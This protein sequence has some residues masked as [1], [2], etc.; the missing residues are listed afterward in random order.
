MN[1]RTVL[2]DS[3]EVSNLSRQA[4]QKNK[5]IRTLSKSNHALT[6]PELQ[7]QVRISTPTVI[8]LINEL[9]T[10]DLVQEEGKKETDNGRRPTL[11]S[12]N[13]NRFYAVGVEILF[14]RISVSVVRLDQKVMLERQNRKFK[15]DNTPECLEEVVTYIRET[16]DECDVSMD[17]ILGIGIGL[18]GRV[19]SLTGE[20][21]NFF[22][23]TEKPVGQYL[24]ERL[25][26][27]VF[28]DNDTH[29]MGL[30][31][32]VL[33]Q[34][35]EARNTLILNVSRGLGMT[36]IANRK[37]ITGGMGF[38][39]EFGHM[40]MG[41]SDK[42]CICGKRGCLGMEVSG[43]ALEENFKQAIK[44]GGTSLAINDKP[45]EDI[46]YDDIL[47]A[48]NQGDGLCINLLQEMGEILGMA[49]GNIVN[50]L[51]PELIIIGGKFAQ[52]GY[53]FSD[54]I[55]TGMNK[56]ALTL[57]LKYVTL[58]TSQLGSESG[59]IGASA[60]VFKQH[61]LI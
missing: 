32:Q 28:V 55:K 5:I 3:D 35:K 61:D 38:A 26:K 34:A 53:M 39:G 50:L 11:Y 4:K 52:A 18:T 8:K 7:K 51:N 30:A 24:T 41:N 13:I 6:I 25:N 16:L 20:S 1:L 58:K 10:D 59:S 37:L 33:G 54:S 2:S 14:K 19:N 56:T 57:P 43:Y 29:V 15:L 47:E 45:L 31:E 42:L 36:I 44:E 27:Q 40:Q 49:L 9:I 22:T 60:M 17:N 48:A 21:Y 23:F 12:L 46:R